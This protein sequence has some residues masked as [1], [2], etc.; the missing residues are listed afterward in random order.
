M[1]YDDDR[2]GLPDA[3]AEPG[4]KRSGPTTMRAADL[5]EDAAFL[6]EVGC[7]RDA[8]VPALAMQLGTSRDALAKAPERPARHGEQPEAG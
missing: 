1:S 6:R 7:L 8:M 5:A 2:I 4:W 3:S